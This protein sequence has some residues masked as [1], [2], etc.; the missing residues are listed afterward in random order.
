[1]DR[2]IIEKLEWE[3]RRDKPKMPTL[4]NT[5]PEAR[6]HLESRL[7]HLER[8]K[9]GGEAFLASRVE[10]INAID[11]EFSRWFWVEWLKLREDK[12]Y[13]KICKEIATI[14]HALY[15][16]KVK[17]GQITDEMIA[18]ARNF[19]V[20]N[21]LGI[22]DKRHNINCPFHNETHG[23]ASIK[24]NWFYCY[25]CCLALDTIGLYRKLHN[26]NFVEAVK[27]LQ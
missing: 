15:P 6:A 9:R 18:R 16:P 7:C 14:K 24:N 3:N 1:M 25:G 19:P 10:A 11:D 4:L 26:C 27:M 17:D 5:F 20:A 2:R 21:I 22:E 12:V 8:L 13:Q 23:S